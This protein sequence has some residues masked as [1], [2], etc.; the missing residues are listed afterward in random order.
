MTARV[1][2]II[3]LAESTRGVNG[4]FLIFFETEIFEPRLSGT[5]SGLRRATFTIQASRRGV[6]RRGIGVEDVARVRDGRLPA[7]HH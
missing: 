3:A 4:A 2:E 1:T 5:G 6:V 7:W